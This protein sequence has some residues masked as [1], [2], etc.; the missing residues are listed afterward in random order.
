MIKEIIAISALFLSSLAHAQLN[1]EM[2]PPTNYYV[3]IGFGDSDHSAQRNSVSSFSLKDR[4][5][6]YK[7]VGGYHITPSI[8]AEISYNNLGASG[9]SG[10]AT[11]NGNVVTVSGNTSASA[12]AVAARFSAYPYNIYPARRFFIRP[13][14]KIGIAHLSA[15]PSL[16]GSLFGSSVAINNR[17]TERTNAYWGIGA[18]YQMMRDI[19]ILVEYESFGRAGG[20]SS[21]AVQIKPTGLSLGILKRF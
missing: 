13:F 6:F 10:V 16:A 1:L 3:A 8:A 17:S 20:G 21:N 7:L 12:Y 5:S 2:P 11:V 9:H 18:E 14:F 15:E 4:D 19:S